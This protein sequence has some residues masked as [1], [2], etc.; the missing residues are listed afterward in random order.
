M[1]KMPQSFKIRVNR[2][3]VSAEFLPSADDRK[4]RLGFGWTDDATPYAPIDPRA[5]APQGSRSAPASSPD[6]NT[7]PYGNG[8][9]SNYGPYGGADGTNY[10]VYGSHS[11]QVGL[12]YQPDL[13][14]L[15]DYQLDSKSRAEQAELKQAIAE[16]IEAIQ[17]ANVR[18][19]A[20]KEKG[21]DDKKSKPSARQGQQLAPSYLL[22][23]IDKLPSRYDLRATGHLSPVEDQ[24]PIGSCT[25]QAVVGLIEYLMRAG[26]GDGHDMSRLFVYKLSRRLLGWEGDTGAYLRTAIKS[27]AMFGLPPEKDPVGSGAYDPNGIVQEAIQMQTIV[28]LVAAGLG[29]DSKVGMYLYNSPEYCETNFGA[30]KFGAIP[31]NVNY[32]YLDE[33]LWYLLDNADAEALVFHSSLADRVAHVVGRLPKLRLLI[34]VE[35]VKQ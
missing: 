20:D 24:G 32:R 34:Q 5:F 13:P 27:V 33:E 29:R 7:G 15:R 10:S 1:N 22:H 31:I 8:D 2:S 17:Q 3:P 28:S 12:G 21:K 30:M 16:M 6:T 9:S 18:T 14:D 19:T 4:G 35:A 11:R 25:A 26:G 23:Q